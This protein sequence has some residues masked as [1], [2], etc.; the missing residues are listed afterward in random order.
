[1]TGYYTTSKDSEGSDSAVVGLLLRRSAPHSKNHEEPQS[2][3]YADQ[4]L[5]WK[6][7]ENNCTQRNHSLVSRCVTNVTKWWPALFWQQISKQ[8]VSIPDSIKCNLNKLAEV[9]TNITHM[10]LVHG[11]LSD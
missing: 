7:H 10:S 6:L 5:S 2:S 11:S 4:D 1:M 3:R 9:S 8:L